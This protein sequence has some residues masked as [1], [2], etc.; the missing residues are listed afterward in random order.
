MDLHTIWQFLQ[1]GTNVLWTL[2]VS[3]A[4]SVAV[5]YFFRKREARHRLEIEYEYEQRRKLRDLIGRYHGLLLSVANNLNCRL[6]N[7]YSN[8]SKSWLNVGGQYKRPPYY[9]VSFV[10]RFLAVSAS[11]RQLENEAVYLDARIALKSDFGFLNYIWAL[12]WVMTDVSLF[13]GLKYDPNDQKDHF[14]GDNFREYCDSC[15]SEKGKFLTYHEFKQFIAKYRSLGPVMS[16]FDSLS[17]AE[18]RFR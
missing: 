10:Y 16:F 17:S 13:K 2:V 15:I 4:I 14:F 18:R 3:G 5:S 12:G 11:V 7:F 8:S 6:W 9:F 1:T